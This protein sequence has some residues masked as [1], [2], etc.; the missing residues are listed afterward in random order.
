MIG[1]FSHHPKTASRRLKLFGSRKVALAKKFGNASSGC[2]SIFIAL[3]S[4]SI[5]KASFTDARLICP[6]LADSSV[7]EANLE[8]L[9]PPLRVVI[10]I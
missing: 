8:N 5:Q 1:I 3:L 9:K 4:I 7:K 6:A 10:I 2:Q